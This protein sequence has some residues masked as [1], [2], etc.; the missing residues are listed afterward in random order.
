MRILIVGAGPTGLTAA[1]ELARRGVIADVI[2]KRKDPSPFSRAVG[3]L[4]RSLALLKASGVTDKLLSEGIKFRELQAYNASRPLLNLAIKAE[5][6]QYGFDFVL[7]LPQDRTEAHL[8]ETFQDLGGTVRYGVELTHLHQNPDGV[9]VTTADNETN[10]YRYVIGAD[11]VHSTTRKLLDL[12]FLGIDLP[13]TWSIADVDLDNW[14]HPKAF[15]ACL[16]PKGKIAVVVPLEASRYRIVS[17]TIDARAAIPF[18]M[19]TTNI[20]REANF[21]ISVRQVEA[22]QKGN[23]FLA[24]DAAHC[25]SPVGGRGMNLGI[26]D[27]VELTQRLIDGTADKY[28]ESRH[29]VGE[30]TIALSERARKFMTSSNP[31]V[32]ALVL[33][34]MKSVSTFPSLQRGL[35]KQMLYG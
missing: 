9:A 6:P 32:R 30:E 18:P 27:A 15:T 17:N 13:E 34:G 4:P 25:H 29:P 33:V 16:L 10:Q 14:R 5:P 24:G 26:A 20:R 3:I 1:V 31:L 19:E 7:G 35:V 21:K 8:L 28:T 2:D 11:G 12:E 22:Y 23:V